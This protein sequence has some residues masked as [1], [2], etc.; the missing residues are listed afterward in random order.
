LGEHDNTIYWSYS[1]NGA[2]FQ[3]EMVVPGAASTDTPA[4][5]NFQ[6]VIYLL[7]KGESDNS[8]WGAQYQPGAVGSPG[9]LYPGEFSTGNGMLTSLGP[10]VAYDNS[11]NL[12]LVWKGQSD[13]TI[14]ASNNTQGEYQGN[15]SMSPQK[16]IPVVLTDERPA[17]AS[18]GSN[19]TD[20]LL[21]WKG[22]TTNTLW[23]GPLQGLRG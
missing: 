5:A 22:A 10:A 23:V 3:P 11:G 16:I 15:I 14:W 20:I 4:I 21:A 1:G 18:Q 9:W 13:N 2:D 8:I 19:N 6:G 12:Y 17:L 7:W